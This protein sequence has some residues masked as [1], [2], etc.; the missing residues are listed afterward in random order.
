MN[1]SHA[2][3]HGPAAGTCPFTPAEV[4]TLRVDDAHAGTAIVGL[5]TGIFILGVVGYLCVCWWVA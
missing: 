1:A 5:M 3:A 2:P 4:E